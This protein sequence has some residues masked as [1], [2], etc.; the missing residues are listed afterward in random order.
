MGGDEENLRAKL[1]A[2]E[3][4]V[5]DPGMGARS[6]EIWA[7]MITVQERAKLLKAEIE[8]SGSQDLAALDEGTEKQAKK[9]WSSFIL[10][11]SLIICRSWKIIKHNWFT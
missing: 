8:K 2:L 4:N 10:R 7:R 1:Q 3:K 5:S 9:V 11:Y 6:E